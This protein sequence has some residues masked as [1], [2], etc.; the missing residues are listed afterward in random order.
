V[1]GLTLQVN[2]T[3][4]GGRPEKGSAIKV[5]VLAERE[6]MQN[7]DINMA[8]IAYF[9]DLMQFLLCAMIN[10]ILDDSWLKLFYPS[11]YEKFKLVKGKA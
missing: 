6:S 9:N 2:F 7:I 4:N 8:K 5:T 1:L 11:L 10:Y 3:S